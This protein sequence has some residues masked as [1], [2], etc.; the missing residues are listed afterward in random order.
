MTGSE[1]WTHFSISHLTFL[2]LPIL[3][4][5]IVIK[6]RSLR[7]RENKYSVNSLFQKPLN[8]PCVPSKQSSPFS[9]SNDCHRFPEK[10]II[11]P[12]RITYLICLHYASYLEIVFQKLSGLESR[13]I[14]EI[15][16]R[17][18]SENSRNWINL[19]SYTPVSS[20]IRA[21]VHWKDERHSKCQ[22]IMTLWT[23]HLKV[24][25]NAIKKLWMEHC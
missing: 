19:W 4:I 2:L 10:K 3:Q 24:T 13:P 1:D 8:D 25:E 20:A 16:C 22:K 14:L 23:S 6:I 12:F 7:F 11:A 17:F 9:P 5:E 18:G 15:G 21:T